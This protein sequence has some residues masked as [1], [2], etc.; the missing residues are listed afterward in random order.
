M[1]TV[2]VII[3]LY[4]HQDTLPAAIESILNQTLQNIEIVLVDNNTTAE[5]LSVAKKYLHLHPHI[6][7][8]VSEKNQGI[9]SARNRGVL[10]AKGKYI[11]FCDEDDILLPSK[12]EKQ[13]YFLENN[14]E[15]SIIASLVDYISPVDERIVES[16]CSF[17]PPFW[18]EKLFGKSEYF[19]KYPMCSPHPSTMFFKRT[20]ALEVG[21]F[22]EK[23]NPYWTEDTEFSLRMYEKGPIYLFPESLT[24]IRLSSP[25]YLKKRQGTVDWVPLKNI[26]YFF[27][28]LCRKYAQNLNPEKN[29]V[30]RK[31]RAQWLRELSLIFL[32]FP[33]GK[34]F[35][36]L[37][38]YRS[39]CD[40]PWNF[41]TWKY[42]LKT[43]F[44]FQ[45]YPL[46]FH[47]NS[48]FT[49]GLPDHIDQ[50]FVES[51]FVFP[52]L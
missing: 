31:I 14:T 13:L 29:D 37:F 46:L 20:L 8:L 27:Q 19:Q 28:I 25:E 26:E 42:Y 51:L 43:F 48:T 22:D 32:K 41:K 15:Y 4:R 1:P 30:L 6:I 10:E 40:N 5:T 18:A 52:G 17:S 16:G 34:D 44:P 9:A 23:F 38:L 21:L 24:K 49:E 35:G 45:F 12:L 47:F 3:T 7:R 39:I 36:R 50:K 33:S 2:S 11:A